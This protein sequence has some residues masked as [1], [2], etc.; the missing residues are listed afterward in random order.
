MFLLSSSPI[1]SA[2]DGLWPLVS[3]SHR[4]MSLHASPTSEGFA[5]P[6]PLSRRLHS[7]RFVIL[8]TLGRAQKALRLVASRVPSAIVDNESTSFLQH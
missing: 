3:D 7:F 8:N 2:C 4:E 1:D 6:F 5:I